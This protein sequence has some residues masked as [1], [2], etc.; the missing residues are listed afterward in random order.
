MKSCPQ[1]RDIYRP[2]LATDKLCSFSLQLTEYNYNE[3]SYISNEQRPGLNYK[4]L[5][6]TK[7][8]N[9]KEFAVYRTR[10]TGRKKERRTNAHGTYHLILPHKRQTKRA[11]IT[12]KH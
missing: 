10:G 1:H 8:R 5:H 7:F 11:Q 4:T 9:Q 12:L 2:D 6:Y 3:P